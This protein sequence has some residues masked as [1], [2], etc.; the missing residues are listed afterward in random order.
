LSL[1]GQA[2]KRDAREF[3]A[4][5]GGVAL[6]VFEAVQNGVDVVEDVPL[7][8]GRVGVLGECLT[9][10]VLVLADVGSFAS[11]QDDREI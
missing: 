9:A 5:V 8:D 1:C 7:G 2:R 6:A 10:F 4:Q 3:A 11:L